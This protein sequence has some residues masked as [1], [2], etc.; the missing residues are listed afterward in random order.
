MT[1]R[2][3]DGSKLIN[4]PDYMAFGYWTVT[5]GANLTRSYPLNSN[6]PQTVESYAQNLSMKGT[7]VK[8]LLYVQVNSLDGNAVFVL[9][10]NSQDTAL[11]ITVP[12][13][14]SG[15]FSA[16]GDMSATESDLVDFQIRTGG[17]GGTARFA[18][19]LLFRK[20]E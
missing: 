15:N 5:L 4:V 8:I 12:A 2:R 7:Y 13:G 17:A 16:E 9:R 18:P 6:S 11:S 19:V 14:A 1:P 20:G 10:K 3:W